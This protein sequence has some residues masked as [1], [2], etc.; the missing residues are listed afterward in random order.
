VS[1]GHQDRKRQEDQG[2]TTADEGQ[3]RVDELPGVRRDGR[4]QLDSA[5][6]RCKRTRRGKFKKVQDE[7]RQRRTLGDEGTEKT[8]AHS[9]QRVSE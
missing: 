9:L 6:Q 5:R 2:G 8:T 1:R 4:A 7:D 3:T